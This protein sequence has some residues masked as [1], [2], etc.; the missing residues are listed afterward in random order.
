M[1]QFY[2][3]LSCK[4]LEHRNCYF[5]ITCTTKQL[6]LF[7][8]LVEYSFKYPKKGRFMEPVLALGRKRSSS[9]QSAA[10]NI[11]PAVRVISVVRYGLCP[12]GCSHLGFQVHVLSVSVNEKYMLYLIPI[13]LPCRFYQ[14]MALFPSLTIFGSTGS[15]E[16]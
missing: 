11:L 9:R 15:N 8:S 16:T 5:L 14:V 10:G 1:F 2:S 4:L 12:R 7:P 6:L 13:K 3:Q